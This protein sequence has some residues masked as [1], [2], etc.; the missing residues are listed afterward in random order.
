MVKALI[1]LSRGETFDVNVL[2]SPDN[3]SH[4]APG[5][6]S[7]KPNVSRPA[8]DTSAQTMAEGSVAPE[9]NP[10]AHDPGFGTDETAAFAG[11]GDIEPGVQSEGAELVPAEDATAQES[12]ATAGFVPAE[13]LPAPGD[14]D[15]RRGAPAEDPEDA[16]ATA[17]FV[18]AEGPP[19][20]ETTT[21]AEAP[22]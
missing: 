3:A 9:L 6:P 5:A 20:Q 19:A 2:L 15:Q 8:L 4:Q 7:P 21:S 18:P 14:L 10:P 17:G 22:F 16:N 11:L 12:K 1:A 13:G